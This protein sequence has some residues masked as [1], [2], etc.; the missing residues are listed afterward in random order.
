[1]IDVREE[2]IVLTRRTQDGRFILFTCTDVRP[3]WPLRW[4]GAVADTGG[5]GHGI[6]ARVDTLAAPEGWTA[7]QLLRVARRRLAAEAARQ[8]LPATRVAVA[9]LNLACLVRLERSAPATAAGGRDVQF[10][11]GGAA[12]PYDWTVASQAGFDL[13]LC[14]DPESQDEGITPEQLLIVADQLL[15]D[16]AAAGLPIP[17]LL[18]AREHVACAL[19]A[20]GRRLADLRGL[21][22]P[23]HT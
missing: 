15:L 4:W 11:A 6:L 8:P 9:A 17:G 16:A 3:I 22:P 19:E 20:E 10:R 14:P 5:D 2:D 7:A 12:S 13:P 1:M 18:Q 21:P 23:P